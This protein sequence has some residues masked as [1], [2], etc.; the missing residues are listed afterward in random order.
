MK[1]MISYV[2]VAVCIICTVM[3]YL[4]MS[5]GGQVAAETGSSYV[6]AALDQIQHRSVISSFNAESGTVSGGGGNLNVSATD[7]FTDMSDLKKGSCNVVETCQGFN[8]YDS[9]TFNA[10]GNTFYFNV[11][12]ATEDLYS[13]Y[14][15]IGLTPK[16]SKDMM[17][18]QWMNL[19]RSVI[20]WHTQLTTNLTYNSAGTVCKMKDGISM[21]C[22]APMPCMCSNTYFSSGDWTRFSSYFA[23]E[24]TTTYFNLVLVKQG[25]DPNDKSQW[26]YLPATPVDV[27]AH[28]YPWGVCQ[29]N[30]R[31]ERNAPGSISGAGNSGDA[32]YHYFNNDI[33][34]MDAIKQIVSAQELTTHPPTRWLTDKCEGS[35]IATTEF[36][37]RFDL[38]GCITYNGVGGGTK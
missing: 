5:V 24:L 21:L 27:K 38:I 37:S 18:D 29:T 19:E 10:E 25:G 22:F 16:V 6:L 8:I 15:S 20:N 32:T 34:S 2:V 31:V 1:K 35:G 4:N 33:G 17:R 7:W 30:L 13:L 23:E 28:T 26:L 9:P 36:N 11:S 12:K 14:E 3:V